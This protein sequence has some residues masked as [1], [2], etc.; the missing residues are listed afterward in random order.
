M[1]ER[2]LATISELNGF[3][4]RPDHISGRY[5]FV[6][7]VDAGS[8][9]P[10]YTNGRLFALVFPVPRKT[11]YDRIGTELTVNYAAGTTMRLGVYNR[12][13]D[14]LTL[15]SLVVDAGTVAL[16]SGAGFKEIVINITLQ[17][18]YYWVVGA[19][20]GGGGGGSLRRIQ[21]ARVWGSSG[22]TAGATP[23]LGFA[24]MGIIAGVGGALPDPGGALSPVDIN[25]PAIK[26]R[27]A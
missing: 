5:Y 15:G 2:K 10:G 25:A 19:F 13:A 17:P 7:G 12:G 26:L 1:A 3:P 11:T 6:M 20:Q 21:Q 9:D 22:S 4:I 23:A 24:N 8:G 16:D 14:L 18:D 27:A